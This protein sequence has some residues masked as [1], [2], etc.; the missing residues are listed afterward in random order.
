MSRGLVMGILLSLVG[1][2]GAQ[3]SDKLKLQQGEFRKLEGKWKRT[4]R[5]D[6]PIPKQIT[7]EFFM[8]TSGGIG[9]PYLRIRVDWTEHGKAKQFETTKACRFVKQD[10]LFYCELTSS[11]VSAESGQWSKYT[12]VGDKLE[13]QK[14]PQVAARLIDLSGNYQRFKVEKKGANQASR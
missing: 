12:I 4:A 9:S 6:D 8:K 1:N 3:A 13:L 11:P 2:L 5:K 7:L 10:K 14:I